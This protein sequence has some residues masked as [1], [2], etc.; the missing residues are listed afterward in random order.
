M[1]FSAQIEPGTG[2]HTQVYLYAGEVYVGMLSMPRLLAEQL[3][4]QLREGG[5]SER[6]PVPRPGARD[7]TEATQDQV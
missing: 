7:A 5:E 3:Q 6:V 2:R 1:T 4:G